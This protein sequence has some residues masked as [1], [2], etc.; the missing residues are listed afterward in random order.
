MFSVEPKYKYVIPLWTQGITTRPTTTDNIGL[1][2]YLSECKVW[3]GNVSPASSSC[4]SY[5]RSNDIMTSGG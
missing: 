1:S 5:V 2:D 3:Y 4:F